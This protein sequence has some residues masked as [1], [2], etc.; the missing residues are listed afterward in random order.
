MPINI[1]D[2]PETTMIELAAIFQQMEGE[3]TGPQVA[4]ALRQIAADLHARRKA[5]ERQR[6]SLR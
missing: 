3:T 2:D 5:Y 1:D 4:L 6:S